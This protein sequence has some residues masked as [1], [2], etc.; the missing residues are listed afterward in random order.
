MMAEIIL[1]QLLRL[2]TEHGHKLRFLLATESTEKNEV[3]RGFPQSS[4]RSL[5]QNLNEAKP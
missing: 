5:W 3:L 1:S 2:Y 4:L